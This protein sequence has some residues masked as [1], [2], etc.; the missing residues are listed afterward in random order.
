MVKKGTIK[1]A[2]Y[3]ATPAIMGGAA[4]IVTGNPAIF[5]AGLAGSGLA[6]ISLLP[7]SPEKKKKKRIKN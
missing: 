2:V 4:A 1:K 7:A 3:V 6:G 5:P